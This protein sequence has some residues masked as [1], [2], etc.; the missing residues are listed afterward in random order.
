M[1]PL[2]QINELVDGQVEVSSKTFPVAFG[3]VQVFP[4]PVRSAEVIV[5]VKEFAPE[6][7]GSKAILSFVEVFVSKIA[8]GVLTSKLPE[9]VIIFTAVTPLEFPI[10]IIFPFELFPIL[11]APVVPESRVR[12]V[13][14]GVS[15]LPPVKVRLPVRFPLPEVSRERAVALFVIKLSVFASVVP[16]FAVAPKAFPLCTNAK[17]AIVVDVAGRTDTRQRETPASYIRPIDP[18]GARVIL[19]SPVRI[20]FTSVELPLSFGKIRLEAV[21]A[22]VMRICLPSVP[23]AIPVN[24]VCDVPV[25]LKYAPEPRFTL[26]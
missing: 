19:P 8:V 23:P 10:V 20:R 15:K 17:P 21:E 3:N 4:L 22:F 7:C 11:T 9:P 24:V 12:S 2:P 6:D 26:F 1:L 18:F 5:P 14:V 13:V 16:R 25:N